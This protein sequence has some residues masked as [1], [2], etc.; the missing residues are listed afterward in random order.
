MSNHSEGE[1]GSCS[2]D[3]DLSSL[4]LDFFVSWR[5]SH[6]C[7]VLSLRFRS[8]SSCRTRVTEQQ[9]A[10]RQAE[11]RARRQNRRTGATTTGSGR[12]GGALGYK[13]ATKQAVPPQSSNES[14]GAF[15]DRLY[16]TP[17]LGVTRRA[18]RRVR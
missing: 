18:A 10:V 3:F 11:A 1:L 16:Q 17:I 14:N 4:N 12:S 8:P 9:V 2:V 7:Q 15:G 5:E 13:V 6:A